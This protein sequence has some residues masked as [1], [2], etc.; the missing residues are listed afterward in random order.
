MDRKSKVKITLV[1][2]GHC[3]RSCHENEAKVI[4]LIKPDVVLLEMIPEDDD[5]MDIIKDFNSRK[6]SLDDFVEKSKLEKH[7][8]PFAEYKPLFNMIIKLNIPIMP[9]DHSL[10]E[11]QKLSKLEKDIILKYKKKE[12]IRPFLRKERYILFQGR[13]AA[14]SKNI[15]NALDN[16]YRNIVAIMGANHL[17]RMYHLIRIFQTKDMEILKINLAEMIYIYEA[18]KKKKRK[19]EVDKKTIL[20]MEYPPLVLINGL[21]YEEVLMKLRR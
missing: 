19:E 9:L 16:G 17:E 7:W 13:E 10:T 18:S 5:L 8:G 20:K 6:I 1:G 14:F 15:L 4:E 2:E 11:R 3:V 21:L 12:D